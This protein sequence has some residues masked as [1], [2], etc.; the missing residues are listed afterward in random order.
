MSGEE[1]LHTLLAAIQAKANEN[2]KR[3]LVLMGQLESL[4]KRALGIPE[5]QMVVPE[6]HQQPVKG[7]FLQWRVKYEGGKEIARRPIYSYTELAA[8]FR[9]DPMFISVD[10]YTPVPA[11]EGS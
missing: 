7:E 9:E 11:K 8:L 5:E 6:I 2:D 10:Q 4:V 3:D 1:A